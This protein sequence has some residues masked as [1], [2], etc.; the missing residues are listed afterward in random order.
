MQRSVPP[1]YVPSHD[2]GKERLTGLALMH[3]HYGT[4]INLDEVIFAGQY[5]H[6]MHVA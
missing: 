3:V 5:P 2:N 4:E 1:Q 6:Q